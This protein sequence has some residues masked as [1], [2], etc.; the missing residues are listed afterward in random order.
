MMPYII[1][2]I[3]PSRSYHRYHYIIKKKC[4]DLY[5]DFFHVKDALFQ[6]VHVGIDVVAERAVK[7]VCQVRHTGNAFIYYLN[8]LLIFWAR[9]ET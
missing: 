4:A 7:F 3:P 1:R 5:V 6:R 8:G 9:V 2:D